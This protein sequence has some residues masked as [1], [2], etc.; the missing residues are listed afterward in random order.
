VKGD[1]LK[2]SEKLCPICGWKTVP[3]VYG[4][5]SAEDVD[6]EDIILGGC[7]VDDFNP[8]LA[9]SMCDWSGQEWHLRA[10]LPPAAW[11]ILDSARVL[12]PIGLVAGRFDEVMEVFQLGH[13]LN[14]TFTTQYEEWLEAAIEKPLALTAPFADLSPGLIAEMRIGDHRFEAS[15]LYEAGF[16]ALTNPPKFDFNGRMQPLEG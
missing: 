11:V 10:P 8:D 13:W 4:L 15:E 12:A 1:S 9:C 16:Q 7:I 2:K 6:R 5:P 3:I 14:V